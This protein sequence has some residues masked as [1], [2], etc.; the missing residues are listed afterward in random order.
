MSITRPTVIVLGAGASCEYRFPL[1][2][3]LL[4]QVKDALT[5]EFQ[6]SQPLKGSHDV[7]HTLTEMFPEFRNGD[8]KRVNDYLKAAGTLSKVLEFNK[9]ASIDEAIHLFAGQSEVIEV[10][11]LAIA[12]SIRSAEVRCLEKGS[13]FGS[14]DASKIVGWM[15]D[16][17]SIAI[18]SLSKGQIREAFKNVTIINFNY[19]RSFEHF[20]YHALQALGIEADEAAETTRS[21]SI[22][23]PYGSL[24]DLKPLHASG[25]QFGHGVGSLQPLAKNIKTYTEQ[26]H[27][28][29]LIARAK[30]ALTNATTVMFLGF[31]FHKQNLDI[32][33]VEGSTNSKTIFATAK[34][35]D[36]ENHGAIAERLFLLLRPSNRQICIENLTCS[37]MFARR[38]QMIDLAVN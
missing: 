17:F 14:Y 24:G 16:L 7:F 4:K 12:A 36:R 19:D 11:K 37:E 27:D 25:V 3:A 2:T 1:G 28:P 21:I 32:L 33:Q 29:A 13:P 6:F 31:G 20:I 23:R 5:Y 26:N 15:A 38:R 35:I 9:H 10:G 8:N 22:L 30:K 18:G 34:D